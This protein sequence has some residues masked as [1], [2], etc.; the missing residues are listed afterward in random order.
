MTEMNEKKKEQ[1]KTLLDKNR[2]VRVL[3][4]TILLGALLNRIR[5]GLWDIWNKKLWYPLFLG[6]LACPFGLPWWM[7]LILS[8]LFFLGQQIY[9]WGSYFGCAIWGKDKDENEDCKWINKLCNK[10]NGRKYGIATLWLR[11]AVWNLAPSAGLLGW[12]WVGGSFNLSL[13]FT[14]ATF[15]LL[16]PVFFGLIPAS[17]GL[18]GG[19]DIKNG[20]WDKNAWNWSEVLWGGVQTAGWLW[21][22]Y[23][24]GD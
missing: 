22:L 17:L 14:L 13:S 16:L 2:T 19:Y 5:G 21:V 6:F 9:G 12:A 3:S 23:N 11:G 1:E 15:A 24:I 10:W 4:L 7:G 8:L 20:P 18:A